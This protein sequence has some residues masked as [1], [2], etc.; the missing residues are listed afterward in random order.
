[1]QIE[2]RT[3]NLHDFMNYID[4]HIAPAV[5]RAAEYF[6]VVVITGPRQS[7]KSTL[8]RHLFKGYNQYNLEDIALRSQV[9]SDPK[10]FMNSCGTKVLID[11]VQHVPELFS[12]IQILVDEKPDCRIILTG[13]SNFELMEKISQ[14]LAGRAAL[15]TLLPMAL[16]E[17]RDYKNSSTDSLLLNG[18]YPSVI[19]GARPRDLFY[20]SYYTT[21]VERDLRQLLKVSN[22]NLFQIF[23]RLLAGRSG[24]EFNA[25]QISTESGVSS[26]TIRSWMSI[27]QTSYIA[28]L[29]PPYFANLNKRLTKTPKVYFYD[30]GLL[31]FLLGIENEQQL[32]THPLRGS[33]FENLAVI[34][35][36][37]QRLNEGKLPNIYFYREN[38]GREVDIVRVDGNNLDI[39]EI[40]SSQTYSPLLKKN[41]I[42]M[43][44]LFGEKV[45]EKA[46][47]YDGDF[48]PPDI[49]NIR[50]F[51]EKYPN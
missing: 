33:I 5:S 9:A 11:E 31:C 32:A 43:E 12:Y 27:L 2:S 44:K 18:F 26:T 22:L 20:S 50:Q 14:S 51:T 19:T 24:S 28:F 36:L 17:L 35:M 4:R 30:T 46:V 23:I 34:E 6:P 41:L 29:L 37:K 8:C 13:S 15:F 38:S 16:D 40:K 1:M 10:A 48:I 47:V 49:I 45:R 25:S 3:F 7:G 42:Y 39:F 21:Y